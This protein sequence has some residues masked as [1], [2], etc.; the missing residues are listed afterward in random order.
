M[1]LGIVLSTQ[2]AK[3]SA[4]AYKG[5]LAENAAKIKGYGFDGIE[6]AIRDPKLVNQA[7]IK[8]LLTELELTV[9]AV[10]TGQAFGEEGLSFVHPDQTI[11][12]QAIDRIKA[13]MHLAEMLGA[14]VIIGLI[15][16]FRDKDVSTH[17]TDTWLVEALRGCAQENERVKLIIEPINRYEC[18]L[19]CTVQEGME[20]MEKVEYP[21]VGLLLDTFHMN[22]EEPSIYESI[23]LAKERLYHFHIADSNRWYPGA[24]HLNF[25]KIIDTLSEVDYQGYVSAEILPLPDPD[26]AAERTVAYMQNYI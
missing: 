1:K 15:R 21:N 25:P 19:V 4:L 5:Q 20:L 26:T 2:S 10:G 18:D 24:G 16:G 8:S 13:Q 11:R 7:E 14:M 17:Q 22:I 9:P 12:H 3:F 23:R 6:L